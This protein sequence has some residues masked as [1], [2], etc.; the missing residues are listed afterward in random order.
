MHLTHQALGRFLGRRDVTIGLAFWCLA[1]SL[2]SLNGMA[3]G[4]SFFALGVS[5]SLPHRR[6]GRDDLREHLNRSAGSGAAEEP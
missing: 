2:A 6:G 1:C 4:V 3:I 5:F